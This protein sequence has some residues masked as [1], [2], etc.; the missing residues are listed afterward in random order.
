[1]STILDF[2]DINRNVSHYC[3]LYF[4]NSQTGCECV[5]VISFEVSWKLFEE[6]ENISFNIGDVPSGKDNKSH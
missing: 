3:P 5:A 1:M 6:F 4:E 2:S